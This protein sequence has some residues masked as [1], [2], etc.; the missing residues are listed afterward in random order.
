MFPPQS[1][2]VRRTRLSVQ[3]ESEQ[4]F[5]RPNFLRPST[6]VVSSVSLNRAA[7]TSW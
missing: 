5:F 2:I 6:T 1:E 4:A 7:Q 3:T